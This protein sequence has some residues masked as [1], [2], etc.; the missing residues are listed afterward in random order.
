M[1][2]ISL[3]VCLSVWGQSETEMSLPAAEEAEEEDLTIIMRTQDDVQTDEASGDA[4][5]SET[6]EEPVDPPAAPL[7]ENP[8]GEFSSR[9][10]G[11]Y[12]SPSANADHYEV[13]WKD[14]GGNEE[15][16]EQDG[17]DWTCRM[18]RCIVYTELPGNGDYTWTVTAVNEGG[19]T[20][21]DEMSFSV[22]TGIPSPDAYR[23]DA[24]VGNQRPLIFEWEDV[25]S[26][27]TDYRIQIADTS[28]DQICF[29]KWYST[30]AVNHFGGVCYLETGEFL[31]SGSYTWR[32]QGGGSSSVS[33]WSR[34]IPFTVTCAECDL[35]T[36]LNTVSSVIAPKGLT[37]DAS[38][39]F[40][41]Q[42]VTGASS[43]KVTAAGSDGTVLLDETVDPSN[44]TIEICSFEPELTLT[45]GDHYTWTVSVYGYGGGFWGSSEG[46]FSLAGTTE[47]N[48]IAFLA[49]DGDAVLDPDNRQIIWTDPGAK[50]AAFRLGIRD[51]AKEWLFI[52]DL[53][54]EDAW[55]DGITCSIQFRDIPEG[56]DYEI[57]VIPYSE[58]NIP[59]NA[60]SMVFD[61]E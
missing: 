19:S 56:Q 38:P 42:T 58:F 6:A 48:D 50:T 35:G 45:V 29:D 4:E 30:S 27:V 49:P 9:A 17:D 55:C 5:G 18:G 54:R 1:L 61:N 36:Y 37:T 28:T 24:A 40:K 44:C 26:E 60:V 23:P 33:G 51:N 16:L 57:A 15:T 39:L 11:F 14:A 10:M 32:V 21:S 31:S 43:Y 22:R 59:G 12:W 2:I 7:P 34:W 52:S 47:M 20:A 3:T 25:G 41:W 8:Q 13:S 46:D 53:T